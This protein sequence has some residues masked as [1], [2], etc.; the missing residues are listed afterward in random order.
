MGIIY[1]LDF[2][3]VLS[4]FA[5]TS[6]SALVPE[7]F[8]AACCSY[9]PNTLVS[10]TRFLREESGVPAEIEKIADAV[11]EE[12]AKAHVEPETQSRQVSHDATSEQEH[13]L[14]TR[15]QETAKELF[16]HEAIQRWIKDV[17]KANAEHPERKI[18]VIP[19]LVDYFGD[20]ELYKILDQAVTI[21][22]FKSLAMR[23]RAEQVHYWMKEN[24]NPDEVFDLFGLGDPESNIFEKHRFLRY[25]TYSDEFNMKNPEQPTSMVT[26]I[27]KHHSAASLIRQINEMK[28]FRSKHVRYVAKRLENELMTH[29]IQTQPLGEL[30]DSLQIDVYTHLILRDSLES[31]CFKLLVDYIPKHTDTQ[32]ADISKLIER[33]GQHRVVSLVLTTNANAEVGVELRF[34][35]LE[36]W[37][38]LRK[39]ITDFEKS[40][41]LTTQKLNWWVSTMDHFVEKKPDLI[42]SLLIYLGSQLKP[43]KLSPFLHLCERYPSIGQAMKQSPETMFKVLGLAE[44]HKAVIK[45]P[46][47]PIWLAYKQSYDGRNPA[48]NQSLAAIFAHHF[49]SENVQQLVDELQEVLKDKQ[50]PLARAGLL[51]LDDLSLER[52]RESEDWKQVAL[53]LKRHHANAKRLVQK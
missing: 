45:H 47:F 36:Y 13:F 38:S 43:E 20:E 17:N 27:L 48:Q 39:W 52:W 31:I 33:F 3:L 26:T 4:C 2:L 24:K 21:S 51:S 19:K 44:N 34:V 10:T 15:R 11:L 49:G 50:T 28:T 46:R 22:K 14:P 35:L 9:T 41:W 16:D 1:L 37:L 30:L 25:V 8:H 53:R 32:V 42:K 7:T 6:T 12:I 5:V 40:D 23:L 18:S 29:L